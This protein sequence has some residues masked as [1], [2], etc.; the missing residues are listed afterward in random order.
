[1]ITQL[2]QISTAPVE[3][4]LEIERARLEYDQRLKPEVTFKIEAPKLDIKT[5]NARVRMSSY[6]ARK[7]MGQTNAMDSARARFDKGRQSVSDA[8][9]AYVEVGNDMTRINEGVT[10]ADIYARKYMGESPVLYMAFL[11]EGGVEISW[12]PHQISTTFSGADVSFDWEAARNVMNY[13]PGSVRM[14]IL[15][16]P[17]IDIEYVGDAIYFPPGAY[18]N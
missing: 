8:T 2:L 4:K 11:P 3:Y 18:Q 9:R 1:M 16:N 12:I 13:V 7:S 10:I 6:E 15:E 5:R 14:V 17:R